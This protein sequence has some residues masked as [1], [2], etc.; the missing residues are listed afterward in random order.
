MVTHFHSDLVGGIQEGEE[1]WRGKRER[2][3]EGGEGTE[4]NN[5]QSEEGER[6][7]EKRGRGGVEVRKG[8]NESVALPALH[9]T[10]LIFSE[11]GLSLRSFFYTCINY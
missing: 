5:K 2:K 3:D 6:G 1:G 8:E 10:V 11:S 7:A 9:V 4:C